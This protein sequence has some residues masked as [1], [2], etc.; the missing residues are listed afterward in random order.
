MN[1]NLLKKVLFIL[2]YPVKRNA[3]EQT[4]DTLLIKCIEYTP[5]KAGMGLGCII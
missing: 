1:L 5:P 2:S 4:G 3:S